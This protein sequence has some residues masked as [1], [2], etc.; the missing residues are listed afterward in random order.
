MLLSEMSAHGRHG[1]Q[2]GSSGSSA[3]SGSRWLRAGGVVARA[4]SA[5]PHQYRFDAARVLARAI[6][7]VLRRTTLYRTW[8]TRLDGVRELSLYG[9]MTLMDRQRVPF[10]P[11]LRLPGADLLHEDIRRGRGVLVLGL[12]QSLATLF[13]RYLHDIGCTPLIVAASA[14][15]PIVGSATSAPALQGSVSL[16][17]RARSQLRAGGVV[18]A[19]LDVTGRENVVAETAGGPIDF[20]PA[21]MR[22]A[23]RCQASILFVWA[24]LERKHV[25]ITVSRPAY[26]PDASADEVIDAVVSHA[27]ARI[28]QRIAADEG[29]GPRQGQRQIQSESRNQRQDERRSQ[30]GSPMATKPAQ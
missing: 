9:V 11:P 12:H 28:E 23:Q 7:P 8:P 26:P 27:C 22:L 1:S 17:V 6:E 14:D 13:P 5:V 20:N 25:V 16:L 24:H 2:S 10:D 3:S 4:L 30:R 29:Q 15:F 21:W 19:M 18:C